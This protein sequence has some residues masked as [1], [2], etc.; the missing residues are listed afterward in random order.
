MLNH[1]KS[2]L[3]ILYGTE[4]FGRERENIECYKT[5]K[6]LGWDVRVF[7]SYREPNGGAVGQELAKHDLLEDVLPF[8]S[9]FAISYF[10]TIKGYAKRQFQRVRGVKP[11]A[12]VNP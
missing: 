9:H 2:I 11:L 5:I 8:G 1:K 10:R 12:R 6:S 4:L 7:G 3:G